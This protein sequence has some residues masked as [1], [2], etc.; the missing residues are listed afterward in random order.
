MVMNF[1]QFLHNRNLLR[2]MFFALPAFLTVGCLTV[3]RHHGIEE[4]F[5]FTSIDFKDSS[6]YFAAVHKQL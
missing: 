6:P 2:A 3:M 1:F 5:S 4:Y